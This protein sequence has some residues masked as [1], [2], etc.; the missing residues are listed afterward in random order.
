M[1][2]TTQL[3]PPARQVGVQ[4]ADDELGLVACLTE[5]L[6]RPVVLVVRTLL[7][8]GN[9]EKALSGLEA[10]LKDANEVAWRLENARNALAPARSTEARQLRDAQDGR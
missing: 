6:Q 2:A 3:Q 8:A 5:G 10:L 9:V 1:A 7:Q 4:A